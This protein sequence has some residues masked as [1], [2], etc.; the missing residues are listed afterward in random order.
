MAKEEIKVRSWM[1]CHDWS[2]GKVGGVGD[3]DGD[4]FSS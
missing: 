3:G 2:A 4:R 1:E